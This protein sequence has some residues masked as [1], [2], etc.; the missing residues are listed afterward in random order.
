MVEISYFTIM[1]VTT[2]WDK[3]KTVN[4]WEKKGG[5]LI[6]L[7]YVSGNREPAPSPPVASSSCG[8]MYSFVS[9]S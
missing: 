2:S 1:D 6:F 5:E 7:R 8:H 3:L 4:D 9:Y